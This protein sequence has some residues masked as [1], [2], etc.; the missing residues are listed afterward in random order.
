MSSQATIWKK[1]AHVARSVHDLDHSL[2][3][4]DRLS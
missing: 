3:T 2:L 4:K 1:R